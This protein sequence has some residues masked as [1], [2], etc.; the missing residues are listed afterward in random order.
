MGCYTQFDAKMI[1][2]KDTPQDVVFLIMHCIYDASDD[3][4]ALAPVAVFTAELPTELIYDEISLAREV[5]NYI[6]VS[7]KLTDCFKIPI[8]PPPELR[9]NISYIKNT[10]KPSS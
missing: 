3:H 4:Y 1:L 8:R 10:K 6:M 7:E 2:R 9:S 5:S